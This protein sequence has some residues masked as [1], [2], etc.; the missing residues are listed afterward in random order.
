MTVHLPAPPC[1]VA[2]TVQAIRLMRAA[3]ENATDGATLTRY[4][5]QASF[6][7]V[8]GAVALQSGTN[9]RQFANLY[10]IQVCARWMRV[11]PRLETI[12]SAATP[13]VGR[14]LFKLSFH[15]H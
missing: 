14:I 7:G 2:W 9:D 11:G 5:R 15:F 13:T 6:N 12:Q 3:C 1:A 4:L 8:T 10:L